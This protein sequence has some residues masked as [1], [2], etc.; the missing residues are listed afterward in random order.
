MRLEHMFHHQ[1]TTMNII[2]ECTNFK[3]SK[4]L[5]TF[6]EEKAQSILKLDAHITRMEY[7]LGVEKSGGV[8]TFHCNLTLNIPGND[9]VVNRSSDEA[10]DVVLKANDSAKRHLRKIKTKKLAARRTAVA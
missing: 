1:N 3:P 7:T 6:I 2:I 9:V 8:S 5:N 10:H 4:A